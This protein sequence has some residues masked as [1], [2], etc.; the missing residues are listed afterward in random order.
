MLS[1]KEIYGQKSMNQLW[2]YLPPARVDLIAALIATLVINIATASE[3]PDLTIPKGIVPNHIADIKTLTAES[4]INLATTMP[5]LIIID[6]RIKEDRRQGY[7][8]SSISLPDIDTNC[9]ELGKI[10]PSKMTPV[11]FYCNGINCE[12]SVTSVKIAK[13]CQYK[14]I[15]W[16]K[17]GFEEWKEKGFQ[18][19]KD[20]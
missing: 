4:F 19:I 3:A 2:K 18:Y 11:M 5:N 12:R 20:R 16:F 14:N 7:I 6:A 9:S 1:G 10:I 8:E 13:S 15:Y 17:G